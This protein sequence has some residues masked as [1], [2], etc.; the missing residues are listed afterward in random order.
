MVQ[1]LFFFLFLFIDMM[2]I[3]L[4]WLFSLFFSMKIRLVKPKSPPIVLTAIIVGGGD[5]G[6][7]EA[8]IIIIIILKK[9]GNQEIRTKIY[10]KKINN[11]TARNI[12]GLA[13]IRIQMR[14]LKIESQ[15]FNPT[16]DNDDDPIDIR[17]NSLSGS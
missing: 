17:F 14:R 1:F 6:G 3:V 10:E 11:F 12:K 13:C 7:V 5:G 16:D 15:N 4:F 8:T 9:S 2:I